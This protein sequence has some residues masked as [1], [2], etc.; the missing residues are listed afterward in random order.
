[1]MQQAE[2]FRQECRALAAVLEPLDDAGL[3][4]VTQ[5]KGWTIDDVIGQ[6]RQ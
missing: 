3:D 2:D 5:F 6:V 4:R 1:M